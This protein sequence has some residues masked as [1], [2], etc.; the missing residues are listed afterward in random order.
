MALPLAPP[1]RRLSLSPWEVLVLVWLGW[2]GGGLGP[3]YHVT[4]AG[5]FGHLGSVCPP[6]GLVTGVSRVGPESC[7]SMVDTNKASGH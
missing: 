4:W 2:G 5:A 6:E 7:A 3:Q 1:P